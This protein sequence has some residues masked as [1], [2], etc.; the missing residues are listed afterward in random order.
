MFRTMKIFCFVVNLKPIGFSYFVGS[1][2][3]IYSSQIKVFYSVSFGLD[4]NRLVL[5]IRQ[6]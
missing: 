1:R 3:S 5:G 6:F 4:G 2:L